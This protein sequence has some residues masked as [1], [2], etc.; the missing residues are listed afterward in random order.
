M[1]GGSYLKKHGMLNVN[2]T[3]L[4]FAQVEVPDGQKRGRGLPES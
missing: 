2:F 3:F 1:E 4:Q